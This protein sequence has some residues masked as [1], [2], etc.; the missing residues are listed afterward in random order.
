MKRIILVFSF[1]LFLFQGLLFAQ[2]TISKVAIINDSTAQV[3][4]AT[5]YSDRM[6]GRRTFSGERYSKYK[7]TAAH[8]YLPMGT[9]VKVTNLKNDKF[10]FVK[11]IDR[12]SKN[13]SRVIDLSKIA[14]KQLDFVRNGVA[15]VKVELTEI[16]KVAVLPKESDLDQKKTASN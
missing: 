11:I 10:V 7:L 2:D 8:A 15:K 5:Y 4:K 9:I 3:G 12:C 14:A 1:S 6:H 16:D 13:S